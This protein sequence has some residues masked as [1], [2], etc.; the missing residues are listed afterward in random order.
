M[1]ERLADMIRGLDAQAGFEA[2]PDMLSITGLG[3]AQFAK[4]MAGLGY[5]ATE[6]TRPKRRAAP[7]PRSA[8]PVPAEAE[9][10]GEAP[11][12][13]RTGRP[14]A[15][16]GRSPWARTVCREPPWSPRPPTR[17]RRSLARISC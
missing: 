1:I 3:Q 11:A 16:R 12:W 13:K 7:P 4:L 10:A 17:R 9:P 2:T 15:E 5:V 14:C 6:G 8:A